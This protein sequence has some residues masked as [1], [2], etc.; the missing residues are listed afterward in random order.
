MLVSSN[1]ILVHFV[2][3]AASRSYGGCIAVWERTTVVLQHLALCGRSEK[4]FQ[5]KVETMYHFV[6]GRK[7]KKSKACDFIFFLKYLYNKNI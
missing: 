6:K 5:K 4:V 3:P 1:L 7:I 2:R